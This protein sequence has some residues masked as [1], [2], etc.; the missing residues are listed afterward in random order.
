MVGYFGSEFQQR[1]QRRAEELL[2]RAQNTR[3]F[4][5]GGRNITVDDPLHLG[6]P[7]LI[8][9]L[10]AHGV[11]ALRM[12]P[13]ELIEET[14]R[15]FGEAGYRVDYYDT[16]TSN[17]GE[18]AAALVAAGV[19]HGFQHLPAP[20]RGDDPQIA[21]IQA[22]MHGNGIV[23]FSG[24]MLC[25]ELTPSKLFVLADAAGEIAA[26]SYAYRPHNAHSRFHKCAWVG[27]IAV[28]QDH[29][30]KQVGRY[31]DACAVAAAFA[32]LGAEAVYELVSGTNLAS[33]KM[34]ESCGLTLDPNFKTGAATTS[35]ER[36]TR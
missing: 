10:E 25:G 28:S 1:Q 15:R 35:S 24:S 4:S 19:P 5:N 13:A 12:L 16:F 6:W 21:R 31:V 2:P 7:A 23:P 8:A 9:E 36:F 11:L 30:G 29:R 17:S 26:T 20:I 33:R 18:T 22:F 14:S 3:G 32:D 27:L 34:V